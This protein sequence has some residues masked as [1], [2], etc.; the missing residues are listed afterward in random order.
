M[1]IAGGAS[2]LESQLMQRFRIGAV[3]D[4]FSPDIA[5]AARAMHELGMVGAELR[6]IGGK[7]VMDLTDAELDQAL[8]ALGKED[9]RVVSIASPLLKCELP[10]APPT[11]SRFQKDIFASTHTFEDQ[12]RLAA[13]AFAIAKKSGARVI[14]VFS[15]WRTIDPG[16]VFER[17]VDALRELADQAAQENLIIGLENEHACNISTAQET[18]RVLAAIDHPNLKVVWDP[19]NAYVSGEKP[20]PSGYRVLDT[21]RIAHVHAK[22]CTLEDHHPVW[23]PLGE[24]DIDWEGQID[25]L[26]ED[27]YNGF[28]HLETHWGGPNGDKLEGSKICGRSLRKL[29]AA[30]AL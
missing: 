21:E 8:A 13:R 18:A 12:P 29:V 16:A 4:E 7:N 26:A 24:G 19:A 3:T 10:N 25:A 9:L 17:I 27:G 15:Y 14:R 30:T 20:F 11:D 28:I 1:A 5:V 2:L 22:D 23:E 6:V